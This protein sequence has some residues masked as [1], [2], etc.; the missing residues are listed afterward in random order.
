MSAAR[1]PVNSLGRDAATVAVMQVL[2]I[3][4][5][6]AVQ[7]AL[8][9]WLG[10]SDRGAFAIC[11]TVATMLGVVF[12]P[13]TDRAA[14]MLHVMGRMPGPTAVSGALLF[15]AAAS[16][17]GFAAGLLG[18][19]LDWSMFEKAAA[20][21]LLL[22]LALILPA[23]LLS[24]ALELQLAA[25]REYLRMAVALALQGGVCVVGVLLLVWWL[26]Q[27]VRGA[28]LAHAAAVVLTCSVFYRT[29]SARHGV[30]VV[31]ASGAELRQ[32]L[33]YGWRYYGARIGHQLDL[34]LG[35]LVL[36]AIAVHEDI[37]IYA[38]TSALVMR[39]LLVATIADTVM[40]PALAA[41]PAEAADQTQRACRISGLLTF[42]LSIPVVV[43]PGW[44]IALLFSPQF[45]R[46]VPVI[47]C[48]A[49]GVLLLGAANSLT[50]YLRLVDRPELCSLAVWCGL[51]TNLVLTLALYPAFGLLGAAAAA[52]V[53][54][55]VRAGVL[56]V[57]FA[58][59]AQRPI[60]GILLP[61]MSDV[62]IVL[63]ALKSMLRQGS[64]RLVAP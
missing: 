64:A 31:R 14:Q 44:V 21:D 61:R 19:Y 59:V 35:V 27:G 60:G 28:L 43:A 38:A 16:L 15:T 26:G 5:A 48:L 32:I 55:L 8:A 51:I 39:L 46:G 30:R 10:P 23:T 29:L 2:T 45:A 1:L 62:R 56:L 50:G 47:W 52:G 3:V 13:G 33:S 7:S 41:K 36:G 22:A 53:G 4:S 17:L 11:I 40:L 6:L 49:P 24:V 63:S 34:N 37:G 12:V 54:M 18:I 20:S 58:R 9:W 57:S 25:R 42:M